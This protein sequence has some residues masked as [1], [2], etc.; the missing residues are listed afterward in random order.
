MSAFAH[1][2]H[3]KHSRTGTSA[4]QKRTGYKLFQ[5][6]TQLIGESLSLLQVSDAQAVRVADCV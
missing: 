1:N 4:M 5:E 6:K 3:L 2:N